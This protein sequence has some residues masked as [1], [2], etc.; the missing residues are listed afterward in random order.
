MATI[1]TSAQPLHSPSSIR[2]DHIDKEPQLT[3][4]QTN[5]SISPELFE[6]LYLA[7]KTPHA[8]E[9]AVRYANAAPLGFLG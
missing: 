5:I 7:P 4:A 2:S 6:K 1:T 8:H 9:R 3:H